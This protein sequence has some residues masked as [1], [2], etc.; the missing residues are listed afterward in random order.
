MQLK[1][2]LL[3]FVVVGV[4]VLLGNV[5]DSFAAAGDDS[6]YEWGPWGRQVT[7]A[8]GTQVVAPA[9]EP[10]ILGFRPGDNSN[11]TPN[12]VPPSI[13]GKPGFTAKPPLTP[14]PS[15]SGPFTPRPQFSN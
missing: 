15:D 5:A 14:G 2:M 6:V 1:R 10:T 12:P 9:F 13:P 4:T 11:V 7:P 8:A 3:V